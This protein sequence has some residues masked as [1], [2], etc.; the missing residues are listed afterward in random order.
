MVGKGK[1][2]APQ[3]DESGYL[4]FCLC[5]GRFGNQ[6]EHLLG[7]MAF[8]KTLNR[9][10][11]IPPFISYPPNHAKIELT[12]FTDLFQLGPVKS[13][14]RAITMEDFFKH[15]GDRWPAGAREGQCFSHEQSQKT[16]RHKEG[17]PFGPFWDHFKVVFDS[18]R[19]YALSHGADQ[20]TARS[21]EATF[22]VSTVQLS[23]SLALFP[24]PH[25]DRHPPVSVS[26]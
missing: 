13:Y 11:V 4:L 12:P 7:S 23:L 8:A 5:M 22:P 1:S 10:L 26:P 25:P 17:N 19:P 6:A 15:F 14:H 9:T 3:W 18:F 20:R 21:W 2:T 24:S 16:C